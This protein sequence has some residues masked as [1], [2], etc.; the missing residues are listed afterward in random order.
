MDGKYIGKG[1]FAVTTQNPEQI[2]FQN[3]VHITDYVGKQPA[4]HERKELW[5]WYKTLLHW[6]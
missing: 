5:G 2:I 3:G 6:G 1:L 4:E